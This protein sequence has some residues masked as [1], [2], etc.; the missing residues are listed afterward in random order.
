MD[1]TSAYRRTLR[2]IADGHLVL[3]ASVLLYDP[4]SGHPLAEPLVYCVHT[5][6]PPA[7]GLD[8]D[9]LWWEPMTDA[10]HLELTGDG[11]PRRYVVSRC[12]LDWLAANGHP[13][14]PILSLEP[15]DPQ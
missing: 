8:A 4:Y 14:R 7:A 2:D 10:G 11:H 3:T 1:S 13:E 6:R 12:G 15:E 5:N 9:G